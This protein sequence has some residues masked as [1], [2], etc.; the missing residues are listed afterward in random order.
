M[1]STQRKVELTAGISALIPGLVITFLPQ[2]TE[3]V[4][5][6]AFG[7]WAVIAGLAVVTLLWRDSDSS[8]W[9]RVPWVITIFAGIAALMFPQTPR[10][11]G[12]LVG[13]WAIAFGMT[14]FFARF[15][16]A[17]TP[18]DATVSVFIAV[19]SVV[20]GFAQ[21]A[22]PTNL[23][24]NVGVLGAYFIVIGVWLVIAALS[25]RTAATD[26]KKVETE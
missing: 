16:S 13:A 24:V 23:V 17:G 14:Q 7:L 2:H 8:P 26:T 18:S 10:M 11:L 15:R 6:T 21:L 22:M 3:Q 1:N 12:A 5:L 4:G 19:L 25:P 9:R 20:F